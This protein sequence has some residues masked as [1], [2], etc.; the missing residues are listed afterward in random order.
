MGRESNPVPS[1]A[2]GFQIESFFQLQTYLLFSF[3]HM[4]RIFCCCDLIFH[5]CTVVSSITEHTGTGT[6]SKSIPVLVPIV[7]V[8]G[9][10]FCCNADFDFEYRSNVAGGNS[11][12]D[13]ST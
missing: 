1:L 8:D 9:N 11:T 4:Y 13:K 12:A 3:I 5:V 7:R 6:Y 10:I 2:V